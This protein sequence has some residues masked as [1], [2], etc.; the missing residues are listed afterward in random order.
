MRRLAMYKQRPVRDA[1][2]KV[3]FEAYQSKAA[4]NTRIVPDRRWFGNTRVV[5][6]AALASFR[7]EMAAKSGDAYTVVLKGKSLPLALLEDPEKGGKRVGGGGGA[8]AAP[9]ARLLSHKPYAETFGAAARRK[10]PSGPEDSVEALQSRA[11]AS[12]DAFE[13]AAEA[14]GGG[15]APGLAALPWARPPGSSPPGAPERAGNATGDGARPVGKE[16]VFAKG[17][18]K[19]IWGELYKVVD[20]SDVLVQVLD[21][22]DPIG[23]RCAALEAHLKGRTQRHRHMVLLLNKAR[24]LG[25]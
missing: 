22:R 13:A 1:K 18:S 17:T 8:A 11:A 15:C 7:T 14:R 12:A 9:R 23:T 4:P 25:W 20:S 5:G 24:S 21:A 16:A 10:R 3:L 2:G 19:R 6:A